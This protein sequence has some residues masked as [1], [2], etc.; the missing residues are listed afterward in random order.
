MW[1]IGLTMIMAMSMKRLIVISLLVLSFS[2]IAKEDTPKPLNGPLVKERICSR[3]VE[4]IDH[5]VF[6]GGSTT[7]QRRSIIIH[8]LLSAYESL[9]CD[10][11]LKKATV[12]VR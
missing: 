10:E 12:Q 4:D 11:V 6:R 7:V 3:L 5:A 9:N 1:F 2:V 8:N